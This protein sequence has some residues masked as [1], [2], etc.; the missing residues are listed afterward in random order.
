[1]Y[2]LTNFYLTN[3]KI[4]DTLYPQTKIVAEKYGLH[5]YSMH[6][7]W[8]VVFKEHKENYAVGQIPWRSSQIHSEKGG[9]Y[10]I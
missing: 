4:Y 8:A 5:P 1:M 7:V 10:D 6:P 9:R 2:N 3:F